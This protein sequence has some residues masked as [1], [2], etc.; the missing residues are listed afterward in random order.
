MVTVGWSRV[1]GKAGGEAG[2]GRGNRGAFE[3]KGGPRIPPNPSERNLSIRPCALLHVM[4]DMTSM[5]RL[6]IDAICCHINSSVRFYR[7][8][9]CDTRELPDACLTAVPFTYLGLIRV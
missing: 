8:E 4:I 3:P 2:A 1:S 9:H 6:S 7:L 5:F